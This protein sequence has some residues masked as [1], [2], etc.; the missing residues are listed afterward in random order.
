MKNQNN[1]R[2]DKIKLKF[3]GILGKLIIDLLFSTVKIELI[4]F[5]EVKSIIASR[6]LIFALWHSRILL[7]CYIYKGNDITTLVSQSKDG[8]IIA[9]ILHY[10]GNKTV[11]GS[12]SRGGLRAL[13]RLIK[14][15][16]E[17]TSPCAV[18]PDGPRGPRFNV[19]PGVITLAKKTGYPI[20]P[21]TY[22][23]NKIK[24]FSSWDRFIIPKPFT[25][26]RV[27]YGRPVYVSKDA[28][29]EEQNRCRLLLE[30]ELVRITFEADRHFNHY[31]D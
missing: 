25:K 7:F 3:T 23:A 26:C 4:G 8:E 11:R 20:V 6:K 5:D 1:K 15:L 16:K 14:I 2:T 17:K 10:Q 19:Q 31:I 30:K 12:T 21:I 27:V 18:T 9:Q 13:A 22:S 28:D 29:N 24:V